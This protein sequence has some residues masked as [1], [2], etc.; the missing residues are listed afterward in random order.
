MLIIIDPDKITQTLHAHRTTAQTS[1]PAMHDM[2]SLPMSKV[3][4]VA[5]FLPHH[6]KMTYG[7]GLQ[8][9][10]GFCYR[11][12]SGNIANAVREFCN[13]CTRAKVDQPANPWDYVQLWGPRLRS[14]GSLESRSS[15][16]GAKRKLT[17][18]EVRVIYYE[19]LGWWLA[20]RSQPYE[21]AQIFIDQNSI[22]RQ[23]VE[24]ADVSAKTVTRHLTEIDPK[25][26]F[27]ELHQ[28]YFLDEPHRWLRIMGCEENLARF[29][30]DKAMVVFVDEKVLCMSQDTCM[31]WFS[32]AHEDYAFKL[33]PVTAQQHLVKIKYII[34][35]NY[36]FGALWIRFFTGTPGLLNRPTYLVGKIWFST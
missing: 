25:F 3:S 17:D 35:V 11:A 29:D 23:I 10:A 32:S 16:S 34:A 18:E 36:Y 21:T 5:H 9:L 33:P 19:A 7:V 20:G 14:D 26:H 8:Y 15:L 12:N 27:G 4:D 31:G 22:V 24:H 28:K 1:T 2:S 30:K 13:V 6:R